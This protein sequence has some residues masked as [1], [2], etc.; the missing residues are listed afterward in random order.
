MSVI[1]DGK[2]MAFNVIQ[3]VM[4]DFIMV[5]CPSHRTDLPPGASEAPPERS[6]LGGRRFAGRAG[7]DYLPI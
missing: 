5:A 7:L 4:N 2:L 1:Q 3:Q 6:P